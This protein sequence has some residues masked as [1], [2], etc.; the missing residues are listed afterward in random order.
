M[1][2][3]TQN[4]LPKNYVNKSTILVMFSEAEASEC[5]SVLTGDGLHDVFDHL[6]NCS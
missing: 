1:Q 2:I 4:L 3:S 6:I 5:S